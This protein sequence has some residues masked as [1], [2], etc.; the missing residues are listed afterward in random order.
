MRL[1]R[2]E[3]GRLAM[4]AIPASG[5]LSAGRPAAQPGKPNSKFAG[6]QVGLNVPYNFGGRDMNW[7]ELL[8]RCLKLNVNA[9]ELRSQPVES[10]L[11]S[12]A[13][14]GRK[15]TPEE[16]RT[17]RA[18]VPV[19]RAAEFRSKY[20]SAGVMI[21]IVKYDGIYNM[22]DEEVDYC[23]HLAKTLGA[24]AISCEIDLKHT[25]RIGRFADKHQLMVGFHGH[26]DT[27]PAHWETAFAQ[28]KFSGANVDLGHF[29]AGNNTS[30]LPFIKQHH[31]RITHVHVKDRKM[32]EGPNVPF[33]QGDTPIKEALQLI[34]DNKWPIQATIEF[35]YPVPDGSDRMAE[36]AK[37]IE[38]C[39]QALLS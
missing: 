28:A 17:W 21:E 31:A 30:P 7:Q 14:N 12:P 16:M 4:T 20:E 13:A 6:V 2:R 35:E 29:V 26:A 24:R 27:T 34:R 9:L 18:S 8:D 38:Y 3:L 33:G 25:Q 15:A 11:G 37:T 32:K 5:V 1:T 10:F 23:F 36:L 19:E 22:A 39:R